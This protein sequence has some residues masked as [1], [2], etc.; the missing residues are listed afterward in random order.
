[1]VTRRLEA[2]CAIVTLLTTGVVAKEV[3]E[4]VAIAARMVLVVFM[5]KRVEKL[6]G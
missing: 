1:M 4:A 6:K 2:L 5:V 3:Q